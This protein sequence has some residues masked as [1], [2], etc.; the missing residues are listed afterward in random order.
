[1]YIRT[2]IYLLHVHVCVNQYG[3]HSYNLY[4]QC[5]RK[6]PRTFYSSQDIGQKQ[7]RKKQRAFMMGEKCLT[8]HVH[9][10]VHVRIYY[11]S[12]IPPARCLWFYGIECSNGYK[13]LHTLLFSHFFG[14]STSLH[15]RIQ[16]FLVY[17]PL[18]HVHNYLH[19]HVYQI[20]L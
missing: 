20:H 5:T 15:F 1:M 10:R 13:N 3:L 17:Y 2:C 16:Y 18:I 4:I 11:Y 9:V 7:E 8:V 6:K 14:F 12:P 19:V